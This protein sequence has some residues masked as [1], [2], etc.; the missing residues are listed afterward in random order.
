M[1][2]IDKIQIGNTS[3]DIKDSSSDSGSGKVDI[4]SASNDTITEGTIEN[5]LG[6]VYLGSINTSSNKSSQISLDPDSIRISGE[7]IGIGS[8]HNQ[9]TGQYSYAEGVGT[10]AAGDASHAQ[11]YGTAAQSDYQTALGKF[12]IPDPNDTYAVIIGNGTDNANRSNALTVGWDGEVTASGDIIDGDGNILSDIAAAVGSRNTYFATCSTTASTAAK[13]ITVTGWTPVTGDILG[14]YFSTA[15][16][17]NVPTLTI[18]STNYPIHIGG[19]TPNGTSNVLKWSNGTL[20]YFMYDGVYFSYIGAQTTGAKTAPNGAGTWYGTCSNTRTTA[21]KTSVITNFRLTPGTIVSLNCITANTYTAGVLT[22]NINSTG[23]SII[24][25]NN[26]A[27]SSTNTL[28]WDAGELLTFVYTGSY[29]HFLGRS[30]AQVTQTVTSGT[31]IAKVDGTAIYAPQITIDSTPTQSSTNAI[32]SGGTYT[33][34]TN[35]VDGESTDGG[36]QTSH[37]SNTGGFLEFTGYD[38]DTDEMSTATGTPTSITLLVSES[39]AATINNSSIFELESDGLT[40]SKQG[41]IKLL[42]E[43]ID[44]DGALPSSGTWST[45]DLYFTDNETHELGYF[46]VFESSSGTMGMKLQ[47]TN[48]PVG[49]GTTVNNFIQMSVGK[50][51]SCVYSLGDPA[52]FR[53]ALSL[54]TWKALTTADWITAGSGWTVTTAISYNAVLGVV[55]LRAQ[56]TATTAKTAGN[57]TLGTVKAAYRPSIR[58]TV[59][60]LTAASQALYIET[61]G[62]ILANTSAVAANGNIWYAGEYHLG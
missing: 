7:S 24:Y 25:V 5:T 40:L 2:Y 15:N 20:L 22:L 10:G 37:L 51:G 48:E 46:R 61:G 29:W 56:F 38:E 26:A 44:R 54:N 47:V 39:S 28:T 6:S 13:E 33:A 59:P 32:S 14:I 16:T 35:K 58:S 49:G 8:T 27:T 55:K 41:R 36:N 42:N 23:G 1:P 43:G 52:A 21:A 57:Q 19:A 50:D 53:R 9:P 45:S 3:Y 31:E 18:N 12:N 60:S 34:L 30:K 62:S 4:S 11:N 17:A